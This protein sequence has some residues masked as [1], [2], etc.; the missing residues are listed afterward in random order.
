MPGAIAHQ[1][2]SAD[3]AAMGQVFQHEQAVTHDLWDFSPFMWAMKPTP[4]ASCSLRG[5]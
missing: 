5:S 3:R 4:Q 1:R 2:I